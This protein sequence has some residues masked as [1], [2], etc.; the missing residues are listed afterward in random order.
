MTSDTV[1]TTAVTAVAADGSRPVEGTS[2]IERFLA[3]DSDRAMLIRARGGPRLLRLAPARPT[4]GLRPRA[5]RQGSLR[6]RPRR[7]RQHRGRGGRLLPCP[8]R[9]RPP[10]RQ[11]RRP[12]P[13][14]ADRLRRRRS[15]RR[16]PKGAP[17]REL[18][19]PGALARR[20]A[21][22]RGGL[23]RAGRARARRP[24]GGGAGAVLL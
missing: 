22:A 11:P 21:A 24:W 10:R 19:G 7:P 14:H 5:A 9:S 17:S 6:V 23:G 16:Q 15:A 3:L 1:T 13:G 12:A 4:R 2:G 8:R 18:P 20:V